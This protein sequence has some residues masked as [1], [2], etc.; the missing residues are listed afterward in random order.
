MSKSKND[1]AWEKI[2]DKHQI[3]NSLQISEYFLISAN[4]INKFREA[5]LMTKFDHRSQLPKLFADNKLSILPV[6][7]GSYIIGEFESFYNFTEDNIEIEKLHFPHF[8][9][10]LNYQD[11]TSEATAINCA[12]IAEI[13]QDFTE[14]DFLYST[15]S[16]RMSSSSFD[17]N[18]NLG[19]GLSKIS[20]NNSQ[21]EIDGGYEGS[22]SLNIIEAKNYISED[23]L[24]RQ[25]FYPYRLW[26]QKISKKVRPIF[27]TYTNGIFH[28][29]EYEFTD[30]SC[31]NSLQLIKQKKYVIQD[32]I[33][34][35][36]I[37]QKI[38][39]EIAIKNE[40]EI[41]FPQADYFDRVINLCEL[42]HDKITLTK[43]EVTQNYD[44]DARQT[45]YYSNA[46][47]YLGLIEYKR[48]NDTVICCLTEKGQNLFKLSIF[49]RQIEFI[50]LILSHAAFNNTLKLYF[51]NGS[52][53]AKQEIIKIM[54]NSNIWN[55]DSESTYLRR[56]S[57]IIS[58]I[59][60]IVDLIEE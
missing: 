22:N 43:E 56:S 3:I 48:E 18:I 29:R 25:L 47:R 11:I 23:F 55:I 6:S 35:I 58:W 32:G 51:E 46:G 37:I 57:T 42:L 33:I 40:P 26:T 45:D 38:L 50:K 49:H 41:P 9:E 31:Y 52:I 59:N 30:D 19:K 5:R 17:F 44:F 36:E 1:S 13:I 12:F 14:E 7:R 53:P 4:D 39:N 10:S 27:L 21:I 2:F 28:F 54:R 34:N 8:L 60:W 16:G 24:V 15:V 20:V